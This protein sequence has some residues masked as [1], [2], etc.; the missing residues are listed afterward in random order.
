LFRT[1]AA[2]NGNEWSTVLFN[3]DTALYW[4]ATVAAPV[5]SQLPTSTG[6][7][8]PLTLIAQTSSAAGSTGGPFVTKSGS[9]VLVDGGWNAYTGPNLRWEMG[10]ALAEGTTG[11]VKAWPG[12]R[13]YYWAVEEITT[14]LNLYLLPA[15]TATGANNY[16]LRGNDTTTLLNGA[17]ACMLA[18]NGNGLITLQSAS[19]TVGVP[20][21]GF[22]ITVASPIFTQLTRST[23]NGTTLL[24]QAQSTGD[25]SATSTG[26]D[27]VLAG[28][29]SLNGGLPYAG[30]VYIRNHTVTKA[31]FK[32]A[33]ADF[34][35]TTTPITWDSEGLDF[36]ANLLKNV[37]R[38]SFSTGGTVTAS[39]ATTVVDF[40]LVQQVTV[41]LTASTA[42]Q[43]RRGTTRPGRYV[44]ILKQNATGGHAI[45]GIT[46]YTSGNVYKPGGVID[47]ATAANAITLVGCVFDGTDWYLS[48][49]QPMK[50]SP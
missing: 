36:G 46:D 5:Y 2:A 27:L 40:Q 37:G 4:A 8:Q 3:S 34:S 45:T 50:V 33:T 20:T 19:L 10:G 16:A 32:P 24:I 47:V 42:L 18:V 13:T 12:K 29:Q 11:T 22:G 49:A 39:T 48:F 31:V 35:Y 38:L 41:T 1:N 14:A 17:G 6:N 30:Y 23:G 26:G 28:G 21:I 15:A 43:L 44:L 25:P 9:G 7:G